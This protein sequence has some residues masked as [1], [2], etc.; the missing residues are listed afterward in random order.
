MSRTEGG[1]R[2]AGTSARRTS[3]RGVSRRRSRGGPLLALAKVAAAVVFAV[4]VAV[5]LLYV[6]LM[7]GPVALNSLVHP[8]ESGIADELAGLRVSIE[9]VALRLSESGLLQFEL[10]NVRVSD[11]EGVPLVVAPSAAVSLSR[12]ALL[13][14]RIA[15]ESLDLMSARL[16]LFYSDDG[17]LSLKFS[18]PADAADSERTKPA[19]LRGPVDTAAPVIPVSD[20]DWTLGRIDLVKVLSEASGRARRQEHASAYLR[21]IGLRSATVI[22]DQGSRKSVWRVPEFDLD[23]DHRRSRSAIAGR[24]KIES[25]AG[26]WELNFRSYEHI[27]AKALNLTVSVQ[28]LVPRGL[29][30]SFPQLAGL[31]GL[32]LPIW[33]DAQLEL[34]NTG[35]ILSGKI[36]VDVAPGKVSLP[37]LTATPMGIDSGH[38]ELSYSGAARRFEVAPSVLSRGDSRVHFTGAI[39]H[40]SQ[41]PDGPGWVFDLMS[42]EASI[43]AEPPG[44]P[45]LPIDHL[46]ARGFLAPERGRAVL[47]QFVLK[48]GGT[49]I[50]AQGG[51]SDMSGAAKVHF[52]GKIGAMPV[53]VFKSLWPG[54]VAPGTRAWVT[55]RLARGH[56]EG[57]SF[58]IAYG[59]GPGGGE[60]TGGDRVSLALEGSN[61]EFAL[62]EGWPMLE[63][64]RGLLRLE[65]PAVEFAAPEASMTAAD[66]RKLG[67]K[68]TFTVD[69]KEAMPR[70]GHIAVR[71]QGPL[72]MALEFLDQESLQAW[73]NAGVS[74]AGLE[75]KLEGSA[76]ISLPLTPQLQRHDARIEGKL[77][78]SDGRMRQVHGQLDAQAINLVVDMTA[79]A[80]EATAEFLIKGVPAKASWQHVH[81]APADQQPPLRI[82]ATLDG[83]QRTQLGLDI[84]DLVQG[85]VGVEVTVASDARGERRIHFRA[86]LANAEVVLESLAWHK[87]KGRP[88]TFECDFAKGGVYPT[89]LRN[90]KLVGENV[91]IAG[92]MGAGADFRVKEFRFPQ[93]S[94]NVISVLEA[95]GKLRADNVWE[96]VA[97]GPTFDGRELFQSFFDI[98]VIGD[99][100]NKQST[101]PGFARR[102]R[103]GGGPL[104]NQPARRE[105]VDAEA[106]REDD[107]ARGARGHG[108]QQAVRGECA[109]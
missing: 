107:P 26:P 12:R 6:R 67:L 40:T 13:R 34:A 64:P 16:R 3:A 36:T 83:D 93:F 52:D 56:V 24:A 46:S 87:P 7:H 94:L 14:G 92:W 98:N 79:G 35:E 70:T 2:T 18:P 44:L 84:N 95:H 43:A 59:S 68:G 85:D 19:A 63:M 42:T 11:A 45:R 49:E 54:W 1:S 101:R 78:V 22:I 50:T 39:V 103:D 41:G 9:S 25:L 33:G 31:E 99:K 97:K 62:I 17:T 38:V 28:G 69:L 81:G 15:A 74:L 88:S 96:V 86:D 23:L 21:E 66:G 65:G 106:C 71:G 108:R 20:T 102:G 10:R 82:T 29:A 57:G 104:R 8:I 32:D 48:A 105:A 72:S 61:L 60:A 77:R 80:A 55:Q 47:H 76:N 109:P 58:R 100:A 75:G 37:W 5:G 73:Q 51:V 53:A 30:R 27:N 90:A 91:A 89:E 4:V